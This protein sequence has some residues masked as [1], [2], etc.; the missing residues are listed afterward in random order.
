M[1]V[2]IVTGMTDYSSCP[3]TLL[4]GGFP[5]DLC[6]MKDKPRLWGM[7]KPPL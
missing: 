6:E 2:V 7:V 3:H 4:T 1:S 5:L